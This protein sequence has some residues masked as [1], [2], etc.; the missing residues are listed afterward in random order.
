MS[1]IDTR[2]PFFPNTKTTNTRS[3]STSNAGGLGGIQRNTPEKANELSNRTASDAKVN[4]NEGIKDFSKIKRA[5]DA[6]PEVDNS[7]K[8]AR[9]KQQIGEGSYQVN[10]DALAD[11][12]LAEEF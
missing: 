12:I 4:I 6:A 1:N 2:S 10:Y 8:I 11:K 3:S 7:E 5:V 9:L